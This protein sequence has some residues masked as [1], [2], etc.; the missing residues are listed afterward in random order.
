MKSKTI[1][2]VFLTGAI[3]NF[4]VGLALFYDAA[5]LLRLFRVTPEQAGGVLV[6]LLAWLVITFGVGYF[7]VSRAP[8]SYVPIIELGMLGKAGVVLVSLAA[9]VAGIISWQMMILTSVDGLYAVLFAFSL[10]ALRS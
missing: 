1:R 3:F 10:R 9:V 8:Q 4:L 6:Q 7:W 5:L 2:T